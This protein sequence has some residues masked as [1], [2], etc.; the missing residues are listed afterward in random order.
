M[1]PLRGILLG[2]VLGA[3]MVALPPLLDHHTAMIVSR[4]LY[5]C[6]I[7]VA[8][9]V[10]DAPSG[11]LTISNAFITGHEYSLCMD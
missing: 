1:D 11:K 7:R 4:S 9:D 2:V 3:A 8:S 10:T 5:D 6:G